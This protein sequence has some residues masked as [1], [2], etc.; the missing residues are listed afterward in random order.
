MQVLVRFAHTLD[1]SMKSFAFA[2]GLAPLLLRL[3]L[4]PVMM[5]AGWNKLAHFEATASWF[6]DSLGLPAPALM[7][8]LA[9]GAEL[10]GGILLL[11]GLATR[12]V[13]VPLM[14]TM[15]VAIT[16]VHWEHGWLAISDSSSWLANMRV[17][18]AAAR[19]ARAIAI[20]REHGDYAWLTEHGPITI[21]NNGIEFAATYFAMLLALFFSGGGRYTSVDYWLARRWPAP[22]RPAAG[23]AAPAREHWSRTAR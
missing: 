14:V 16:T 2:D 23:A 11:L 17:E 5:Q 10:G 20:L 8:A 12:A 15:L 6:G 7:A 18:E 9:A 4:A 22:P 21:L 13:A 19:K 3:I 1:A